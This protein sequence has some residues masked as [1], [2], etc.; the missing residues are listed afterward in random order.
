[1]NICGEEFYEMQ[2]DRAFSPMIAVSKF[3][4]GKPLSSQEITSIYW[5]ISPS[6]SI[7]WDTGYNIFDSQ[8]IVNK[9]K[10]YVDF[11]I[12]SVYKVDGIVFGILI[13]N[14]HGRRFLSQP[15][16]LEEKVLT[17]TISQMVYARKD[18]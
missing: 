4:E 12:C 3:L 17:K 9:Y 7:G 18:E 2:Y 6:D 10:T 1:M 11:C 15:F 5:G 8:N 16:L 13:V 14:Y